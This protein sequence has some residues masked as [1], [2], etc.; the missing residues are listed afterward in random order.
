MTSISLARVTELLRWAFVGLGE[1]GLPM[2]LRMLDSGVATVSVLQRHRVQLD[3][4]V[5]AGAVDAGDVAGLAAASDFVSIAV[6]DAGQIDDLLLGEQGLL[7]ALGPGATILIHST[8]SPATVIRAGA[9]AQAAGVRLVDAAVTGLPVE[10]R[11]GELTFYVGGDPADVA[12]VQPG[13]AA[14]GRETLHMG[15]LGT[16]V[17]TK[18]LNNAI[19]VTSVALVAE[20]VRAG[21]AA[22]IDHDRLLAAF[23]SGSAASFVTDHWNFFEHGWIDYEGA[24]RV[25]QRVGKDLGLAVDLAAGHELPMNLAGAALAELPSVLV[26]LREDLG[27]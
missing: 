6:R 15:P 2:A 20:A 5:A 8:V 18:I 7:V 3:A 25:R 23:R 16:G 24:E 21:V 27:I 12:A 9:A 1:I 22:G 19:S 10:A 13:L 17:T 11:S 4:A 26:R 14:M